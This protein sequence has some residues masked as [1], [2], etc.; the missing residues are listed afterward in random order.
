MTIM[1]FG[2][3]YI[4]LNNEMNSWKNIYITLSVIK[5]IDFIDLIFLNIGLKLFWQYTCNKVMDHT[6]YWMDQFEKFQSQM[7]DI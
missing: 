2:T 3:S 6:P 5:K 1:T 7:V 4:N